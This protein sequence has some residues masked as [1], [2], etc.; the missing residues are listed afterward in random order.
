MIHHTVP[1]KNNIP[2]LFLMTTQLFN[3][4]S[5]PSSSSTDTSLFQGW[6][7]QLLVG[8]QAQPVFMVYYRLAPSARAREGL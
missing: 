6:N 1:V 3:D 2:S 5:Q 8:H 4:V 7:R